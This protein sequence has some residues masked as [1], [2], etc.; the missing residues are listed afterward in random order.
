MSATDNNAVKYV[1]PNNSIAR[2]HDSDNKTTHSLP[3][4]NEPAS[5]ASHA[6]TPRSSSVRPIRPR[7]FI[8]VNSFAYAGSC[9]T[10]AAKLSPGIVDAQMSLHTQI[11]LKKY[12]MMADL[13][14]MRPGLIELTRIRCEP[15]SHAML[16]VICR[17]ALLEEWYA[18]S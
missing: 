12:N 16:R 11:S 14:F 2:T 13:V 3:V 17:M 15:S 6:S 1:Q 9:S 10:K 8:P 4:Q 5:L 7:G 18:T